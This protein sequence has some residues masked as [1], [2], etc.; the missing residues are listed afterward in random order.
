MWEIQKKRVLIVEDEGIVAL[1]LRDVLI[2]LGYDAVGIAYSGPEAIEKAGQT[3]PDI[4]LMDIHLKGD[5]DGIEATTKISALYDIPVIYLTA[6]SDDETIRRAKQTSSYGYLVKP[7]N[8]R[9]L[10]SMIEFAIY[11]NRTRNKLS[12]DHEFLEKTLEK[13]S[14]SVVLINAKEQVVYLNPA[15]EMLLGWRLADLAGKNFWYMTDLPRTVSGSGNDPALGALFKEDGMSYIPDVATVSTRS[16]RKKVVILRTAFTRNESG[17][18]SGILFF[19]REQNAAFQPEGYSEDL[20]IHARTMADAAPDPIFLVDRDMKIVMFNQAFTQM[21]Q[22]LNISTFLLSRPVYEINNALF[23]ETYGEFLEV[24]RTGYPTIMTRRFTTSSGT[25]FLEIK[26]IPV[27]KGRDVTHVITFMRDVTRVERDKSLNLLM[28]GNI[29]RI[30]DKIL[31]TREQYQKIIE[32]LMKTVTY[33][34]SKK[35]PASQQ[36]AQQ[37]SEASELLQAV[38]VEWLEYDQV[39]DTLQQEYHEIYDMK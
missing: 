33:T 17:E 11:K 29:K 19:M 25:I 24:Y 22:K 18:I 14:Q 37:A 3:S 21:C 6:Y 34:L 27:R 38:R 36:I 28:Y 20:Q 15:A 32:I 10:Y 8:T 7:Y 16:G 39:L 13:S 30:R 5:M 12:R 1:A 26:R 9:E 31:T 35:D 4:I 2:S 23:N